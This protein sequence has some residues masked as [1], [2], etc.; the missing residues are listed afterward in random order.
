MSVELLLK[1]VEALEAV[2][3]NRNKLSVKSLKAVERAAF[4][5]GQ[6]FV[7]AK[8]I[9]KTGKFGSLRMGEGLVAFVYGCGSMYWSGGSMRSCPVLVDTRV[10]SDVRV[11]VFALVKLLPSRTVRRHKDAMSRCT[12]VS[13][14]LSFSAG[15]RPCGGQWQSRGKL[16]TLGYLSTLGTELPRPSLN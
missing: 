12:G 14:R 3:A 1:N 9:A 7:D 10:V 2:L 16:P 6:N 11:D 4:G 8:R 13:V 5:H 15:T